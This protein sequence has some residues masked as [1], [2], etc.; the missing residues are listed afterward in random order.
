V[1]KKQ[2]FLIVDTETTIQDTV[3]DFGA[4][5]TDR[6][7]AIHAQCAVLLRDHFD[8]LD[9]FFTGASGFWGKASAE[10]RREAYT[11]MLNDGA[12]MLA[13]VAAVNRWLE[14]VAGKYAPMLTAYNLPFDTDKCQRTGIDLNLFDTRFCLW[15]AA[16]NTICRSKAYRNFVV[17][18]HLFNAP[19]DKGNMTYKTDA[20]S[21]AGFLAGQMVA[22]PHTAIEDAIQFE[23]PILTAILK[24]K[25][26][27]DN[28]APYS[29]K[30]FQVRSH[31]VAR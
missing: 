9:L 6:K 4:V 31:F 21:V 19:T 20:E 23:L 11:K 29:W 18:H 5:V 25:A 27:R 13:S 10:R 2:F 15:A 17:E 22:E 26:W 30:A 8:K 7:G 12:R 24:R 3:A 1:A 16:S 14:K 28:I